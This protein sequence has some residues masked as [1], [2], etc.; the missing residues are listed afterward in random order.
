MRKRYLE[1]GLSSFSE[2]EVL[3]LV[4]FGAI[5]R[6]NVNHLA[7]KLLREFGSVSNIL[8]APPECIM[9]IDGA[10]ESVAAAFRLI[11]D[12]CRYARLQSG[13]DKTYPDPEAWAGLFKNVL[14]DAEREHF[15]ML[16]LDSG[17]NM[18]GLKE[19][20]TGTVRN[21]VF[22]LGDLMREALLLEVP[23]VVIAH[24]HLN[25]KLEPSKQDINTTERVKNLLN[26]VGIK[27]LDHLI[28]SGDE[29]RS[30]M[31]TGYTVSF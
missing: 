16:C 14:A 7:H 20:G 6:G 22:D 18:K 19:I 8:S 3:E 30:I 9:R 11:K 31:Y 5:P 2:H 13:G 25:M 29:F 10:K 27:L 26:Q 1:T 12:I 4:L 15:Y 24:N 21:A 23:Y 17:Y 28:I